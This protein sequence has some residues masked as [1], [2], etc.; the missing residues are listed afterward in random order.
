MKIYVTKYAL[1]KGIQ[2]YEGEPYENG[3]SIIYNNDFPNGYS[4]MFPC[5]HH[6][7]MSA[8]ITRAKQMQAKKVKSLEKQLEKIKALVSE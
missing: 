3:I 1:T 2:K 4:L 5:D 7:T 6:A 8:A